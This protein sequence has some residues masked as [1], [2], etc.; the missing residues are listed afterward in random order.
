MWK[1]DAQQINAES[2]SEPASKTDCIVLR[3]DWSATF[4]KLKI[5]SGHCWLTGDN[6][7][8]MVIIDRT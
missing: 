2:V 6:G 7:R 3:Q 1:Y 4:F 5:S 8:I